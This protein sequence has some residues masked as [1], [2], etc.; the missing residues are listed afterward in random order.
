MIT[1][2]FNF[3]LISKDNEKL[4]NRA[5]RFFLSHKFKAFEQKCR[6]EAKS[7]CKGKLLTGDLRVN[8]TAYYK[9]K[10]HP[11]TG[12]LPKSICD[13]LNKAIWQDDHQIKQLTIIVIE[14]S[15]SDCFR[16]DI[17]ELK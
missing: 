2:S 5:G 9:N 16:V 14:N 1:I 8:I 15:N 6:W 10:V 12:N 4:Y 17:K 11:D 13:S 7:Q 3:R